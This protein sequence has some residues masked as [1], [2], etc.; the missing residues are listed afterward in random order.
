MARA[1]E[2]FIIEGIST[3]IPVHQKIAADPDFQAGQFDTRFLTR[4]SSNGSGSS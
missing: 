3:S 1:L 2:M 4:F